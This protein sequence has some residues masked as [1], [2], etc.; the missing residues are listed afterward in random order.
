MRRCHNRPVR[1]TLI[2]LALALALAVAGPA[3]TASDLRP[4]PAAPFFSNGFEQ[5]L[6]GFNLAGVGDVDPTVTAVNASSGGHAARFEL[7]GDQERSELIVGGN[8]GRSANS[9]IEFHEG[10]EAWLG[11]SFNVRQM[12]WGRVGVHN[13][14]MQLK[15]EGTG[16]PEFALQLSDVRGERGFWSSGG[17]SIVDRFL[18]PIK[19]RR[20]YRAL[21][22]FRASNR[23]NGFFHLYLDGRLIDERS[24]VSLI[25]PGERT[26]Y[27]KLG[28]YRSGERLPGKSVVL[29]DAVK[30]GRAQGAVQRG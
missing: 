2:A 17:A 22:H 10:D 19:P 8:G 13:L 26:A 23:G 14:I 18:A 1:P 29:V 12:V 24:Q 16:S 25:E 28:L 30:L 6:R 4:Q 9:T 5:G 20:W 7:R 3:A 21:L 27:L 15:S 11:F